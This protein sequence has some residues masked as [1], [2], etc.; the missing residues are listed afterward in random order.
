VL[1]QVIEYE[2]PYECTT[3]C[4]TASRYIKANQRYT[5][6]TQSAM[7]VTYSALEGLE[8]VELLDLSLFQSHHKNH[9]IQ[10][11]FQSFLYYW[12]ASRIIF[13]LPVYCV[14]ELLMTYVNICYIFC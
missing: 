5:C 6:I 12:N 1:L 9:I 7:P 13:L 14:H 4:F 3:N 2:F 11:M 10:L 8:L